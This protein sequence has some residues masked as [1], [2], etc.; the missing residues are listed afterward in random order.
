MPFLVYERWCA[1]CKF[2][3]CAFTTFVFH[4][5]I[6]LRFFLNVSRTAG[7]QSNSQGPSQ[8]CF[9]VQNRISVLRV[10]SE[11]KVSLLVRRVH[12]LHQRVLSNDYCHETHKDIH[13]NV[14]H[15][16]VIFVQYPLQMVQAWQ[17]SE[18]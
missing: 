5:H 1:Q 11:R 17:I 12:R 3:L 15:P 4:F 7:S 14:S 16:R 13:D 8:Q 9:P 10:I 18:F 6:V 2:F